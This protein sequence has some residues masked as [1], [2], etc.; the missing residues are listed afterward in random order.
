MWEIFLGNRVQPVRVVEISLW[1]FIRMIASK[2]RK[3]LHVEIQYI[4]ISMRG[5][6]DL[7]VEVQRI[8]SSRD[9]NHPSMKVHHINISM[10]GAK[11]SP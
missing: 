4:H 7:L 11:I 5:R 10:K 8:I 9:D 6:K 1:K 2:G 3:D